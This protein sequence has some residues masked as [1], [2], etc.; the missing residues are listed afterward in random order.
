TCLVEPPRAIAPLR[1]RRIG[2]G[3]AGHRAA[4]HPGGVATEGR[5]GRVRR[6]GRDPSL[7]LR[8]TSPS[9]RVGARRYGE[10]LPGAQHSARGRSGGPQAA[11]RQD[12]VR[13]R[14]GCLRRPVAVYCRGWPR[15]ARRLPLRGQGVVFGPLLTFLQQ[16]LLFAGV[17]FVVGC[18]AWRI[19][20]APG[21]MRLLT[22]PQR[23][24]VAGIERR[25]ASAGLL[26]A[27]VLLGTWVLRMVVQVMAFRDPFVPL[28][29]DVSFLLFETF[30]GTVWMAQGVII[31][32]L[33]VA[34]WRASKVAEA[35]SG[36][37]VR[38]P[39]RSGGV[40]GAWIVA[41]VLAILLAV[42]LALSGHAMSVESWRPLIVTSDAVHTLA[43]GT[44][45]GTL[46]L[47]L[48]AGRPAPGDP[49]R[50]GLFAAQIRSFSPMAIVS[51]AALVTM[52]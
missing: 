13:P 24:A 29:E 44:W 20:V 38:T 51:V 14:A 52:G 6:R 18:V 25:I 2:A 26:T 27:V 41:T 46:G 49:G 22:G 5:R 28:S 45:I 32:L 11:L 37:E 33:A 16:W 42:S 36:S 17:S 30:W 15:D 19:V 4:H 12:R 35:G 7:L 1:A 50:L 3:C 23:S 21:A 47:I 48:T 8:C 31:P 39:G 9:W 10:P 40:A 34:F 43:A